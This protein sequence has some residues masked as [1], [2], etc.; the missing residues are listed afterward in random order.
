MNLPQTH[1][2][3]YFYFIDC[4]RFWVVGKIEVFGQ[5]SGQSVDFVRLVYIIWLWASLLLCRQARE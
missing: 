1:A 3:K 5:R 4:N 2:N